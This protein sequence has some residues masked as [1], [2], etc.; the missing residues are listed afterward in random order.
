MNND[1]VD[2]RPCHR[3]QRLRP[4]NELVSLRFQMLSGRRFAP[5]CPQARKQVTEPRQFIEAIIWGITTGAS[6]REISERFGPWSRV[7]ERS[8]RWCREGKWVL[9]LQAL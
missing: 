3:E 7:A 4:S 6:C 9:I 2:K 8:Y 5:Y 1:G